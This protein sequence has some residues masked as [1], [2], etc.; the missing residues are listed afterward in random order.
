MPEPLVS[1]IMIFLNEANF[2]REA[3]ESVLAQSYGNWELLLV[4]DGST[5]K[6]SAIA[7]EYV[8]RFPRKIRYFEHPGHQN[9]GMSASRNLGL[10]HAAGEYIAFLD[11]DDV[12]LPEKL[13][14]QVATMTSEP[15]AAMVYGRTVMWYSW[16]D[17]QEQSRS[18]YI[19]EMGVEPN[20][21]VE[22]PA[23]LP[24]LLQDEYQSPTTCN[25]MIRRKPFQVLGGSQETFRGM[26]EDRVL[27]FKL[28]LQFPVFVSGDCWAKYR[29]HPDSCVA[30]SYKTGECQTAR[31]DLMNWV[32]KYLK[33][34]DITDKAIRVSLRSILWPY[35]HPY[36]SALLNW[37]SVSFKQIRIALGKFWRPFSN[38]RIG[39]IAADPNPI[40]ALSRFA[41]GAATLSWNSDGTKEV[42]VR[43]NAPDGAL[44]SRSGPSGSEKTGEW[45]RNGMVF[46]LQDV[47]DGLPLTLA[48]TLASVRIVIQQGGKAESRL[49]RLVLSGK[50]GAVLAPVSRRIVDRFSHRALVLMYHRVAEADSDPLMLCVKPSHFAEH[51]EVIKKGYTLMH[52]GKLAQGVLHNE[53][54]RR[55]VAVTF[56]DGYADN[57]YNAK[58]L[59]ERC[60]APATVFVV[61]SQIGQAREYWW[62]ELERLFLHPGPLPAKL[63][64]RIGETSYTWDLGGNAFDE[65]GISERHV[66]RQSPH[67]KHP[68]ARRIA[69]EAIQR[70]LVSALPEERERVLA[71]L[72]KWKGSEAKPRDACRSLTRE[73]VLEL[74]RGELVEIGAHTVTHAN[75]AV[76]PVALQKPEIFRSKSVLDDILGQSVAGFAYP[77]G[78]YTQ[79]SVDLVKGAGFHFACTVHPGVIEPSDDCFQLPRMTVEDWDGEEFSRRLSQ[80]FQ[81]TF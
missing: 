42:E 23:L 24:L 50:G 21:L 31:S 26:Y 64:M 78:S 20:M 40:S 80:W 76:L 81:G 74:A 28:C 13:M 9:R 57:L 30:V 19:R 61:T 54:P 16:R 72:R 5:D 7:M 38:K 51:L 70:M 47:S 45:L 32:A 67:V 71:D 59:L 56:D 60:G 48:N 55:T 22:P 43:L 52:A 79:E 62:Y 46:Y 68:D 2:I 63:E 53:M 41:L 77:Y 8:V 66:N 58:P 1:V 6:G 69:F 33:T 15:R 14:Q 29:Q 11:A 75:L 65:T 35:R 18:D 12:W 39:H 17:A 49:T 27:F 37:S 36:L 34:H 44:F 25:A 4:D 73:E 3:I 10:Y